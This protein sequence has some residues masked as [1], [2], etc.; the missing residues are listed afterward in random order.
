MACHPS[1]RPTLHLGLDWIP[2]SFL[3][4][5]GPFKWTET[6]FAYASMEKET[7]DPAGIFQIWGRSEAKFAGPGIE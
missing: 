7:H 4:S 5:H 3:P 2:P 6:Y 1:A